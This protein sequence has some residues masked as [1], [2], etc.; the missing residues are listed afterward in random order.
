MRSFRGEVR[1]TLDTFHVLVCLQMFVAFPAGALSDMTR[2]DVTIRIAAFIGAISAGLYALD[3]LRAGP[4][5]SFAISL[6]LMGVYRGFNNPSIESIFADSVQ[7]SNRAAPF[8]TKFIIQNVASSAGPLLNV[9]FFWAMGNEWALGDCRDLLLIGLLSMFPPI[10]IM[11]FF[12][13]DKSLGPFPK[14]KY[15]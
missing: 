5:W 14:K 4:A 1:D 11:C 10:V 13:D 15:R 12:N 7:T 6:S 2:R 3:L 9:L 8:T